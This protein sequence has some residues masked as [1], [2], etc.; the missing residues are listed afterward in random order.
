MTLTPV[1]ST[2]HRRLDRAR[3]YPSLPGRLIAIFKHGPSLEDVIHGDLKS[4]ESLR[5]ER[6]ALLWFSFLFFYFI[7]FYFDDFFFNFIIFYLNDFVRLMLRGFFF[8]LFYSI[9]KIL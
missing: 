4:Q 9:L 8:F 2:C 6:M 3:H 1:L 5:G 7:I